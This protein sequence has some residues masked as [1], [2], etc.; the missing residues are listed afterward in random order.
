MSHRD[1]EM[2]TAITAG[3]EARNG[4]EVARGMNGGDSAAEIRKGSMP[5]ATPRKANDSMLSLMSL[6]YV[7]EHGLAVNGDKQTRAASRG[8][9]CCVGGRHLAL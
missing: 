4:V 9:L 8:F 1:A 3:A 2:M 7:S 5:M 6:P